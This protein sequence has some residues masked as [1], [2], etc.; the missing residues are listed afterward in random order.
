VFLLLTCGF[1]YYPEVWIEFSEFEIQQSDVGNARK[2]LLEGL[3]FL[4]ESVLLTI[5]HS[6][7]LEQLDEIAEAR[8]VLSSFCDNEPSSFAYA[9]LQRFERRNGDK[10]AARAV[11]TRSFGDREKN[12]ISFHFYIHHAMMEAFINQEPLVAKKVMSLALSKM[13]TLIGSPD[14]VLT[15]SRILLQLGDLENTRSL[16]ERSV[17]CVPEGWKEEIWN[18]YLQMEILYDRRDL[19]T[20][21]SLLRHRD[22]LSDNTNAQG[23]FHSRKYKV[24]AQQRAMRK[25]QQ[26]KLLSNEVRRNESRSQAQ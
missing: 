18:L 19:P 4:P 15:Y 16:Y 24:L 22:E 1:C 17:L 3:V 13:P 10:A 7:L 2:V 6:E 5:A 12:R 23:Y 26:R 8:E 20:F 14:F 21:F 11:F 9:V 25:Q